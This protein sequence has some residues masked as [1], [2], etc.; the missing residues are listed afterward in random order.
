MKKSKCQCCKKSFFF[1][2]KNS[3]G[4]FCGRKCYFKFHRKE[5]KCL[6]CKKKMLLQKESATKFCSQKCMGDY[7]KKMGTLAMENSPMWEGGRY[8]D[9]EGYVHIKAP[10][11]PACDKQGYVREHRL[12]LEEKLGRYLLPDEIPHHINHIID[13]NR[14]ENLELISDNSEH[15]RMH[16]L[17]N[18]RKK[19]K[20]GRF[21]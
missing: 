12:V 16:R 18:P 14:P 8:K 17:L 20:K 1:Q 5:I 9:T 3:S 21:I 6:F 13:D 11:H 10:S 19:D 4:K 7:N 2:P 15:S